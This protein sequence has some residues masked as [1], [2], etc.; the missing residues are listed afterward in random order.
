MEAVRLAPTTSGLQPFELLV[1]SNAAIRA[2]IKTV[3]WNQAQLTDCSH[4]LVFA[5]W[6][7]ITAARVNQMFD[8]TNKIRG[9]KNEGW[10]KYRH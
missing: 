5:A 3:A 4:L 10:E 2:Q 9:F 6:D 1:V 8:L 7:D